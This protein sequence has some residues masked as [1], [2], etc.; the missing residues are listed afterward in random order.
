MNN[1]QRRGRKL[2]EI[3]LSQGLITEEQLEKAFRAQS[4]TGQTLGSVLVSSLLNGLSL[5][6]STKTA[7]DFT[8]DS[9]LKTAGENVDIR[10]GVNFELCLPM[11]IEGFGLS[12]N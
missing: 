7:V 6:N 2:G 10:Y 8:V 3:L 9:I 11:L 1:K 4:V 12:W 5:I